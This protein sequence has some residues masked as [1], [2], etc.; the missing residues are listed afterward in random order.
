M[1]FGST[2]I[3]GVGGGSMA[4]SNRSTPSGFGSSRGGD[5]V[6]QINDILGGSWSTSGN[7]AYTVDRAGNV[8][9]IG[10]PS[11]MGGMQTTARGYQLGTGIGDTGAINW[12]G[13][14][15]SSVASPFY[16][17]HYSNRQRNI[18][19]R[20]ARKRTAEARDRATLATKDPFSRIMGT[21]AA[22]KGDLPELE[23]YLGGPSAMR[24][25]HNTGGM[26]GSMFDTRGD[27]VQTSHEDR[28]ELQASGHLNKYGN[29]QGWGP[30][31]PV[32]FLGSMTSPQVAQ[33]M[34]KATYGYTGNL[35]AAK[36]LGRVVRAGM[37]KVG[38]T[39]Q[40]DYFSE[41]AKSYVGG[42]PGG[43]FLSS[44][45]T[46]I[47]SALTGVPVGQ[48]GQTLSAIDTAA[49]LNSLGITAH[50]EA[51]DDYANKDHDNWWWLNTGSA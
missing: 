10:S 1:P 7:R 24:Q 3:G 39:S 29:L 41:T 15:L 50:P 28:A 51:P 18:R 43:G 34:A 45:P 35:P 5:I 30:M 31:N 11:R 27:D 17:A 33:A 32:G 19:D 40:P 48:I 20:A 16:Q 22:Y 13:G 36:S 21:K 9:Q 37:N 14:L 23:S 42:F 6:S 47:A 44:A 49:A 26:W 8:I 4:G 12:R 38:T 25:T 46:A 2:G